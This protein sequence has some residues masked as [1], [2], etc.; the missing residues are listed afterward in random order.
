MDELKEL[1][2][3]HTAKS[4]ILYTGSASCSPSLMHTTKQEKEKREWG[5]MRLVH[6]EIKIYQTYPPETHT[7]SLLSDYCVHFLIK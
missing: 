6:R 1:T 3:F 4:N 7:T 2:K 5:R